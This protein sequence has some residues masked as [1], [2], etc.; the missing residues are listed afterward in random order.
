MPEAKHQIDWM[1]KDTLWLATDFGEGSLTNSGYARIAKKWRRGTPL[2]AAKTV[3]EASVDDVF[4]F[5][6]SSHTPEARF[7]LV[8][9]TPE[10]FRGTNY[11]K[12]GDRLV[13]IDIPE[14]AQ[15]QGFFK[16]HML[17]SL[18]TDWTVG[19]TT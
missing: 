4:T 7:D 9:V 15:L 18:R 2:E 12:L 3:F 16:D 1:D 6:Y 5:A 8:N 14:D 13:K 17:V 19:G 11:L 10:F